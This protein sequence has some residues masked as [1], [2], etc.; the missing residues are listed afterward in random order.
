MTTLLLP[1]KRVLREILVHMATHKVIPNQPQTYAGYK[2]IHDVLGLKLLAKTY[3]DSLSKQGLGDLAVWTKENGLPAITGMVVDQS[4]FKPGQ[5]Y[6]DLFEKDETD[7]EWWADEIRKSLPY[8]WAQFLA[9]LSFSAS[10]PSEPQETRNA[11]DIELPPPGRAQM[12]VYRILRDTLVARRVKEKYNYTCQICGETIVLPDGSRYSEAH[13][14]R[15]LG[16]PHNGPDVEGNILCLC[17]NHHAEVDYGVRR[18]DMKDL[19]I[20][21]AHKLDAVYLTYHNERIFDH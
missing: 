20:S 4:S 3:G 21:N 13:H 1:G 19:T 6:F 16:R 17:P 2:Q 7:Y 8:D 12:R 14:I 9:P 5:G 15:P 18:L 11:S 10:S